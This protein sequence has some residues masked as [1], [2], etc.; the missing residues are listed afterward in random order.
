M[1]QFNREKYIQ[2]LKSQ[3]L[4]AAITELH[5]DQNLFEIQAFEGQ[6]G[7]QRGQFDSLTQMHDLSRELWDLANSGQ[8]N[9]K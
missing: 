1:L 7:Y 6:E 3:G 5:Q 4:S 9:Q 2:I 8:L